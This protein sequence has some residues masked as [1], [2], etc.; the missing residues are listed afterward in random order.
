MQT[1]CYEITLV[2]EKVSQTSQSANER[3][4][5]SKDENRA[6]ALIY[7]S[8]QQSQR[9]LNRLAAL[10]PA[11]TSGIDTKAI[12]HSLQEQALATRQSLN[13]VKVHLAAAKED[14]PKSMNDAATRFLNAGIGYLHS[15]AINYGNETRTA[16]E[17]GEEQ[18]IKASELVKAIEALEKQSNKQI[19]GPK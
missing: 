19:E 16:E 11:M 6:F 12:I 13:D 14:L 1:A 5:G 17:I 2:I 18:R 10:I 4:V 15:V 8:L 3:I 9:D 7:P